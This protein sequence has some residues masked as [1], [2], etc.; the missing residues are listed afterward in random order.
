M[1]INTERQAIGIRFPKPKV[2]RSI[3]AGGIS[4]APKSAKFEGFGASS[5][6]ENPEKAQ[7]TGIFQPLCSLS[8]A[9]LTINHWE[10]VRPS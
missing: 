2:A 7:K 4:K 9:F 5:F 8:V 6:R 3:R 10:N 1:R